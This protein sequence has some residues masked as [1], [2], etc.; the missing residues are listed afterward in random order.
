MAKTL[1]TSRLHSNKHI[2]KI[3]QEATNT[4][5]NLPPH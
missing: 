2:S 3:K 1:L 5:S 4:E